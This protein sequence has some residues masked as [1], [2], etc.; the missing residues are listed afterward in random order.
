MEVRLTPIA[1]TNDPAGSPQDTGFV[2]SSGLG[3]DLSRC[4]FLTNHALVLVCLSRHPSIVLREVAARVGITER[5][6][7]R[8]IHELDQEGFIVREKIGRQNYYQ[9]K[10]DRSLR[11]P[12]GQHCS[13]REL[14]DLIVQAKTSES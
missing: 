9:V 11:H 7:Q 1:S 6:V 13:I 2:E 10:G 14:L 8:I 3:A 5:A 12:I 4:T